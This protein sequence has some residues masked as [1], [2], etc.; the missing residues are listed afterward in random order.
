MK[1]HIDLLHSNSK[2][3]VTGGAGFIGTNIVQKIL[4][5]GYKVVVLDNFSTGK[6]EN[7]KQFYT[8]PNFELIN[9]DIRN[10][11]DCFTAC[12]DIDYVLHNAALRSVPRSMVDPISTNDINIAGTLNMLIAAKE[13]NV[14]R[15]VYASSSSVYGEGV[16]LPLREGEEGE[17][18]SVYAI[19]KKTNEMYCQLFYK[20]FGLPTIGLRYFNVFGKYQD[21]NSKYA[22]VIPCFVKKLLSSE[23]PVIYG[24]GTQTR[25]FTYV[26]N[27]VFANLK[28][29]VADE[30]AF[31]Q[32]FNVGCGQNISLLDLYNKICKSME[33]SIEP[34]FKHS[35]IGDIKSTLAS[36]QK[37]KEL[38]GYEPIYSFNHGLE[39]TLQWYKE[40]QLN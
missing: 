33:I 27:V 31:G 39:K 7:V 40:K 8:N 2:F 14:K 4:E 17:L 37:S 35:R 1:S 38:I 15:F 5:L 21:P 18:V 6:K 10:I 34:I 9:G 12:A 30:V 3:L 19:T 24:D 28:A 22:T 26:G 25:D 20:Q 23:N 32:V 36:I 13:K 11:E 16:E 29:C